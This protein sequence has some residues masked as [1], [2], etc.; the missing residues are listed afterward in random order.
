MTE[1]QQEHIPVLAQTLLEHITLP[2]DAVMVDCTV[3]YG[4][5]SLLFGKSLSSEG[6]IIGFDVDE[7]CLTKAALNLTN[8]ACKVILVRENFTKIEET[9]AKYGLKRIDFILADLG[10]CSGQLENPERGLSFQKKMPLDMRLDSRIKTTAADI[11]NRMDEKAAG[12]LDL[13]IRSGAC[14]ATNRP[15][16]CAPSKGRSHRDDR[17]VGVIGVQSSGAA[18]DGQKEQNPS[19]DADVSGAADRGE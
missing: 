8:M 3:G 16:H 9:V 7:T 17:A 19:G 4:G 14:I 6:T 13:Q 10:F 15:F 12:R 1:P 2:A 18:A 5:H 11:I